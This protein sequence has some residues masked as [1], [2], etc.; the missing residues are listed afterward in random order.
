MWEPH[1]EPTFSL[2]TLA[3]DTSIGLNPAN[4]STIALNKMNISAKATVYSAQNRRI[5]GCSNEVHA[6]K[7]SLR[8]SELQTNI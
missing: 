6:H 5:S 8:I 3:T 1:G 7:I 2:K 4:S